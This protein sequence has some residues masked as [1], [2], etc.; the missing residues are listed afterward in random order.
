MFSNKN[1]VIRL[2][3]VGV[4]N[5]VSSL[6]QGLSYYGRR[7]EISVGLT[8]RILAG[9]DVSDIEIVAAF[10][11]DRRKVGQ[12]LHKAIFAEPN[13]AQVFEPEIVGHEIV[14]QPGPVLDGMPEHMQAFPPHLRFWPPDDPPDITPA[15]VV[16][17]L[18]ETQPDFL[19]CY[20][21]V[22]AITAARF[23]AECALNAGVSL[24]NA[25]PVF[26]A[27]DPDWVAR[28]KEKDLVILGDDVKSQVGAT[29]LH[30]AIVSL[31]KE[32]GANLHSTYQIN[33][34]G[35]TDFL[36]MTDKRRL[37]VKLQSKIESVRSQ[38][39]NQLEHVYAGPADYIQHLKDQKTAY[40]QAEG[41]GFG[42]LPI[43][44]DL[45]VTVEDSPNSAGVMIDVVRLAKAELERFGKGAL[46]EIS[47][48]GFKRPLRQMSDGYLFEWLKRWRMDWEGKP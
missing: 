14:V 45:K 24:I 6:L 41:V 16:A 30:R 25:M 26:I 31:C 18:R 4:G 1:R 3:V 35:N 5:C 8:A 46:E 48:Y 22:G 11:I 23:Y 44:I 17:H 29:I 15:D 10:D 39:G 20:L 38:Y 36:N 43:K 28:F 19:L 27:S 21:P 42:G 13:V 40:I 33:I 12:P 47:A 9:Y 7:S 2:A 37:A 34:G 32:R